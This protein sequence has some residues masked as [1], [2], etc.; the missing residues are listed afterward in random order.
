MPSTGP[1]AKPSVAHLE[2]EPSKVRGVREDALEPL[3]HDGGRVQ[4]A[5][6]LAL[7]VVQTRH[8]AAGQH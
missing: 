7:G 5:R 3:L 6:G 8:S 4:R 2:E 1:Q